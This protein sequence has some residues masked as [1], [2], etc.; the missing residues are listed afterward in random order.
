MNK[1]LETQIHN[2]C[3]RIVNG[4]PLG[5]PEDIQFYLNYKKEIEEAL[6]NWSKK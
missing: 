5:T 1:K 6:K 2:F 4:E 3:K